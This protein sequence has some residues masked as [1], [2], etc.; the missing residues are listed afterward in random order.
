MI[1]RGQVDLHGKFLIGISDWDRMMNL[2]GYSVSI[3]PG[4]DNPV[5]L[6]TVKAAYRRKQTSSIVIF[7]HCFDHRSSTAFHFNTA[8]TLRRWN[9]NADPC[10]FTQISRIIRP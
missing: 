3:I 4:V 1:E 9:S 5:R 6:A 8:G 10:A 7:W 2:P